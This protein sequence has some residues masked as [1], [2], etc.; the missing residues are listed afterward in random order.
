MFSGVASFYHEP[1]ALAGGGTFDPHGM[2]AAHRTLPLGTQVR[3]SD[4]KTGRSVIVTINDR[5]PFVRGRVLDLS[6]TAARALGMTSRG[7]MF[8]SATVL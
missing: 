1:Q 6:F 7:V 3:V 8:V 5:G 4:P 2:T